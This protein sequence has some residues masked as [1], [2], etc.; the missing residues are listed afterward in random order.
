MSHTLR[1][2][3]EAPVEDET[4][5]LSASVAA[6]GDS[7]TVAVCT[8]ISRITGVIKVAAIGAVLGPTFFG[9]TFQLTNTLPNLIYYG[10]LAGSL[11]SSL[12]VPSLV[13]HID[14]GDRRASERVAGGFLGLTMLALLAVTPIA[15]LLG[16]L[17]LRVAGPVAD[18]GIS[19]GSQEH[20]GRMLILMF[21]PQIFCYGVVG[22]ATAAMNSRRKFALAAAAP[23]LEN[24]GILV[25]LGITA[26][27]FGNGRTIENVPTGELL[28][29]GLGT[30]GAVFLHACAQWWGARRAGITLRPR[31]GWRDSEVRAL[32]K[33]AMPSLAQAGLVALQVL[34]L[35]AFANRVP[36]GVVA[37]QIALNFYFLAIA[38]GATPV[39]LSLLPRLAR[40]HLQEDLAGFRDTLV[41]GFA[42]GFFVAVP[43]AVG[44]LVLARPIA[45]AVAVG[46]MGTPEGI[47][48]VGAGVATLALAVLGQTAFTLATYASYARK[49]TRG[50]LISMIVQAGCCLSIASI[51]F[52]VHG[53]ATM[54]V[55]GAA[56]SIGIA[57]A[58]CHL[59]LRLR[60][61]LGSATARIMPSLLKASAGAALMAGPAWLTAQVVGHV[62]KPP[63]SSM[64]AVFSAVLVGGAVYLA[65]QFALRTEELSWLTGGFGQLR[66]RRVRPKVGAHDA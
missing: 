32:V 8:L 54:A 25:V 45:R 18:H 27:A 36:G 43:S 53:A 37:F 21:I 39:S 50:P 3:L 61:Q 14:R 62:V 40:L 29:L 58:A 4:G 24:L 30:T 33:R 31:A 19:A 41:R 23:A 49:D 38:L 64:A 47:A 7:I 44:Y 16:P 52:V 15:V 28:L 11:F 66:S 17:V 13:E 63:L 12:L 6:A 57:V 26:V 65:S 5:A 10:F 59:I 51:A 42:L 2:P 56:F 55:L 48:M 46:R 34:T 35:L 20:V 22:A 9:N 60:R 1:Q